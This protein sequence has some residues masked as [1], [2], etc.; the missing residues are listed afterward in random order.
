VLRHNTTN[1]FF[2][3]VPSVVHTTNSKFAVKL[4]EHL[5]TVSSH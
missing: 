3:V 4:H 5:R 1:L 2:I